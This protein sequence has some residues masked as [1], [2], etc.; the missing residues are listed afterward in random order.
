MMIL[1]A[2]LALAATPHA[3]VAHPSRPVRATAAM[4]WSRVANVSIEGGY[5]M[6]NPAAP[7]KLVEFGSLT[8]PHCRHFDDE[9]SGPLTATYIR[10]GKVSYEYRSFLLNGIDI[11]ATLV[12]GCNG[13]AGFFAM[14]RAL[15]AS[16]PQWIAKIQA[17]PAARMTQIQAMPPGQQL[18]A[19]GLAAGFPAIA[20]A[21]GISAA[22]AT[23]CMADQ[24]RAE[25]LA[26]ATQEAATK[27]GVKGTPTFLVNGATVDY[28]AGPTVWGAVEAQLK[29]TLAKVK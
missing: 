27:Y 9:A 1:L 7:V 24:P 14:L 20:A 21:H 6:G 15:Y 28:S 26:K 3:R 5:V 10:S 4:D 19:I 23:S 12:A 16:Q 22:R 18:Q 17:I 2:A 29:S 8:C 11:P 13:G 25:R